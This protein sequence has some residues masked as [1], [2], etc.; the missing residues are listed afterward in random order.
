MTL[1]PFESNKYL[2][3]DHLHSLTDVT[4]LIMFILVIVKQLNH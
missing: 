4:K 1:E 2:I 3:G